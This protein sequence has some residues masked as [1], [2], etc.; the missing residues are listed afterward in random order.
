VSSITLAIEMTVAAAEV[1][2]AK[3]ILDDAAKRCIVSNALRTAV[4]VQADIR[5][6]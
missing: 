5:A 2:R 6:R 4:T 3:R 1:E